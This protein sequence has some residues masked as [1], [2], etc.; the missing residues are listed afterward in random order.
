MS[1]TPVLSAR[2]ALGSALVSGAVAYGLH[3]AGRFGLEPPPTAQPTD[4]VDWSNGV[5]PLAAAVTILRLA[6]MTLALYVA[7]VGAGV[8]LVSARP[9]ARCARMVRLATPRLLRRALGVGALTTLALPAGIAASRTPPEAP[10]VM[11]RIDAPPPSSTVAPP[12]ASPSITPAAPI[13]PRVSPEPATWVVQP[14]DHFWSIATATLRTHD[15]AV[16]DDEVARYWRTLVDANRDRLVVPGNPDLVF[17][18][19]DLVLPPVDNRS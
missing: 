7:A 10:P 1:A 6:A 17:A 8:V 5:G 19:Q 14:G 11:I 2:H 3:A 9:S 12:P 15:A 16:T 13:G 4:L 18:G